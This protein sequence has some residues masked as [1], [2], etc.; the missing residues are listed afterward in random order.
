MG[1]WKNRND[2]LNLQ[3]LKQQI[4]AM[5]KAYDQVISP[6]NIANTTLDELQGFNPFNILKHSSSTS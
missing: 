1:A 2:T 6:A 4:L 3:H 5:Y